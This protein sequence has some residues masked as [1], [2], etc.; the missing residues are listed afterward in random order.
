M[1][2]RVRYLAV[3][4]SACS[5]AGTGPSP[6][7]EETCKHGLLQSPIDLHA[8]AERGADRLHFDYR[9]DTLRIQN[10]GHTVQVDHRSG[11]TVRAGDQTFELVQYHMHSP[12]E[13]TVE[14]KRYPL[15]IHLVHRN[16]AGLLA[17]VGVLV[18]EGP[19]SPAEAA[20]TAVIWDHLPATAGAHAEAVSQVDPATLLPADHTHFFYTGSLT[21]PPCTE[22]VR[23][24]VMTTP[25]PLSAAHIAAFRRL[26]SDN[27]RPVQRPDWCPSHGAAPAST[28]AGGQIP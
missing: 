25:V 6:P 2:L 23:W 27:A 1:L 22:H 24:H 21:T 12:S 20:T 16:A 19:E 8:V 26:Y 7:A 17:V 15:E 10:T 9:P 11:S 18:E 28:P 13:H 5:P 14:G 4:A 3:I